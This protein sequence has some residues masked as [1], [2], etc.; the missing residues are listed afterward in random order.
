VEDPNVTS[1]LAT[2]Y[3]SV[4]T[5]SGELDAFAAH[6]GDGGPWPGLLLVHEVFGLTEHMEE[7]ARRLAAEGYF[8]IVPDLYSNDPVRQEITTEDIERAILVGY[9]DDPEAALA[10]LPD[11]V[12]DQTR[13]AL[14]W[15]QSIMTALPTFATDLGDAL[16]WLRNDPAVQSAR[17]GVIGWCMGGGLAGALLAS[18]A[19]VQAGVVYYGPPPPLDQV[20]KIRCPVLGHYGREDVAITA[21]VPDFEDAM[22]AAGKQLSPFHYDAPHAF[23]NDQRTSYRPE[24]AAQAWERTIA[25]LAEHLH[26]S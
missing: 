24:A 5:S 3:I 7:Q 23:N 16:V 11:D 9:E 8:A 10:A 22:S 21:K 20:E 12:R 25:F 19:D 17:I 26:R 13:R 2:S 4:P 15:R 18:G 14:E 6:P 1:D